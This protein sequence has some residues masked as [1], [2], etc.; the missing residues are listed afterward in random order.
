M[1]QLNQIW[2]FVVGAS[3]QDVY[4][5][6]ASREL[7]PEEAAIARV[8]VMMGACP[9]GRYP[10]ELAR[11]WHMLEFDASEARD[12]IRDGLSSPVD[13]YKRRYMSPGG[14]LVATN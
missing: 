11:A 6:E 1:G 9:P 2:D 10:H 12:Y 7:C 8:V 3:G 4:L 5:W 14:Q 13:A